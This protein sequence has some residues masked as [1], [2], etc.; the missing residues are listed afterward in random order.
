[1]RQL[2]QKLKEQ[3]NTPFKQ[4]LFLAII[5]ILFSLI[6]SYLEATHWSIT[7]IL[8]AIKFVG[9]ISVLFFFMRAN[10]E[11]KALFTYGD[12]FK[13]GFKITFHSALITSILNLILLITIYKEKIDESIDQLYQIFEQQVADEQSLEVFNKIISNY[14]IYTGCATFIYLVIFGSVAAAIIANYTK[15]IDIFNDNSNNINM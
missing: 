12:S 7:F 14:E 13:N 6:S 4:G 15:K 2:K 3:C 5:T 9:C 8:W 11:D 10:S 1:M